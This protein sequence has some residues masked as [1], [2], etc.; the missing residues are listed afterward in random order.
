M[1]RGLESSLLAT[2]MTRTST[3]HPSSLPVFSALIQEQM[4]G[5]A[6]P[7]NIFKLVCVCI[8]AELKCG[9]VFFRS[10]SSALT[11]EPHAPFTKLVI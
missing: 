10:G 5:V 4:K 3:E 8:V 11:P 9:E 6:D 7:P 1:Y 2:A